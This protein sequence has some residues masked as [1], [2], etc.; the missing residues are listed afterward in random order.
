MKRLIANP[1]KKLLRTVNGDIYARYPVKTHVVKNGDDLLEV[2]NKYV[3]PFVKP[4]DIIFVSE[5]MVAITQ[6]RA[7]CIDDIKPSFTAKFL[8]KFVYKSPYGIGLGSPWTMELALREVG[9]FRILF[10]AFAAAITKPFGIRGVFYKISGRKIAAID[11]PCSYTLPPYNKY[12]V[13]APLN[14]DKVAKEISDSL[15]ATVVIVDANDL[16]VDIIGKSSKNIS[17]EFIKNAIQ[18]NPL[19]QSAQQ[20]PIGIIRKVKIKLKLPM[21]KKKS[22]QAIGTKQAG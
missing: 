2:M 13:L 11:G 17:N 21:P 9:Y 18:D 1:E 3:R 15:G 19:G 10:A 6:G 14:P 7:Y 4:N 20:T 12:A 22:S 16:G 5:K 8:S